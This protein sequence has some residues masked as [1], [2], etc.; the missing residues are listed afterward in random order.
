MKRRL[1]HSIGVS[2]S[3]MM[4]MSSPLITAHGTWLGGGLGV[5]VR[6]LGGGVGGRGVGGRGVGGGGVGGGEEVEG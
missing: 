2:G 1:N 6:A 5:G 3:E 4:A